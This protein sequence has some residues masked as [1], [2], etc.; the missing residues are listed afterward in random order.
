MKI[1]DCQSGIYFI[2]KS[3]KVSRVRIRFCIIGLELGL[4]LGLE[5]GVIRFGIRFG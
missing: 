3:K 4:V 2:E 5:K 1:L